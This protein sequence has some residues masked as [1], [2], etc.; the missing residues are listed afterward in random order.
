LEMNVVLLSLQLEE[1]MMIFTIKDYDFYVDDEYITLWADNQTLFEGRTPIQMY[2][3]FMNNF[4]STFRSYF[5]NVIDQIQV[6]LGP[7]GELRYPSYQSYK[8][9]YCGI[10][11][12]QINDKFM[13]SMLKNASI[14]GG[15]TRLG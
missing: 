14:I 15:K 7:S 10:G 11:E 4:A 9:N 1:Q 2:T 6:G 12:F 3:D 5:P 13:L 8:W